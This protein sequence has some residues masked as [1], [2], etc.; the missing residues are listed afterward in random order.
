MSLVGSRPAPLCHL[1]QY[2][3]FQRKRLLVK[4]GLTGWA[5]IHDRNAI[6][7]EDRIQLD[8]WYLE[9]WSL[10]L[11]LRILIR[12]VAVVLGRKGIYGPDGVNNPFGKSSHEK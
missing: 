5:V 3:S 9:N 6:P 11:D 12:S 4:P 7:W 1:N 8:I 10:Q 2:T